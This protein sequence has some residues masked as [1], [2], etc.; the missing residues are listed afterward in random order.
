MESV[1]LLKLFKKCLCLYNTPFKIR[2]YCHCPC[3]EYVISGKAGCSLRL[4]WNY[5]VKPVVLSPVKLEA[6]GSSL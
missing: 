3:I 2:T 1:S 4:K 6:Y 5:F